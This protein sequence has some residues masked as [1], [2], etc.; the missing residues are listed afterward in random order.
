MKTVKLPSFRELSSKD[1]ELARH[2][3]SRLRALVGNDSPVDVRFQRSKA[4][5]SESAPIPMAAFR[6]LVQILSEM[7]EGNA[8]TMVPRRREMTTQEAADFLEMSR[9]SL[10]KLLEQGEIRFRKVG[11]HRRVLFQDVEQYRKQSDRYAAL[12]ELAGQAQ[13]LGFGY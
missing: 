7:A 4:S 8:V 10:L 1:L 6:M 9:P 3:S 5:R 2:A 12:D 13:E 11:K